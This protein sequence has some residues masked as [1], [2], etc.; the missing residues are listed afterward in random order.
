[1]NHKK[2]EKAECPQCK[3]W[4]CWHHG[5]LAVQPE[6]QAEMVVK[7]VSECPNVPELLPV[8]KHRGNRTGAGGQSDGSIDREED[9]ASVGSAASNVSASELQHA[10]N[11][12]V[13]PPIAEEQRLYNCTV[14]VDFCR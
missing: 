12:L 8:P 9:A 11:S 6:I 5:F 3:V 10:A 2:L 7:H 14:S 1:M 13:L 4:P